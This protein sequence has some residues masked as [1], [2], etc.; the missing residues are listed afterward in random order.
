MAVPL[1]LGTRTR[2]YTRP[3]LS[4]SPLSVYHMHLRVCV[5]V[6]IFAVA[7]V[8]RATVLR[9]NT[10]YLTSVSLRVALSVC[11]LSAFC[12]SCSLGVF[13]SVS[14]CLLFLLPF[15]FH[16]LNFSTTAVHLSVSILIYLFIIF[17]CLYLPS[18]LCR[19]NCIITGNIYQELVATGQLKSVSLSNAMTS[20]GLR[21]DYIPIMYCW[22]LLLAPFA[23]S[24]VFCFIFR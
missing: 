3:I 15:F 9:P 16:Y 4:T 19:P 21:F 24:N 17:L 10:R 7:S 12:L 1:R 6:C 18:H 14:C 2:V 13:Y 20:D 23:Q 11:V 5:C 22:L 8:W